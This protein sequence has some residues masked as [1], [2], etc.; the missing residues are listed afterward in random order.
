M[1]MHLSKSVEAGEVI[2]WARQE[3]KDR[4]DEANTIGQRLWASLRNGREM[5]GCWPV[6]KWAAEFA[7]P[8][9]KSELESK[10][11]TVPIKVD[12]D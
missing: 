4:P 1:H 5:P 9:G 12:D 2:R 6:W 8:R 10:Y 11:S 7:T 3:F